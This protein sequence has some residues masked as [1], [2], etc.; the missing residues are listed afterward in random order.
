MNEAIRDCVKNV[1]TFLVLP[2]HISICRVQCILNKIY[3]WWISWKQ[4]HIL[5]NNINM[6]ICSK[7]TS[8]MKS[9][10]DNS[11][12]VA[13]MQVAALPSLC[14]R[15]AIRVPPSFCHLVSDTV[16]QRLSLQIIFCRCN[17]S[18][19]IGPISAI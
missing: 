5:S 8:F 1:L 4:I 19:F 10:A 7:Y 12:S 13:R 3:V 11:L 14:W 17:R 6:Y 18:F 2:L 15:D 9:N 16:H